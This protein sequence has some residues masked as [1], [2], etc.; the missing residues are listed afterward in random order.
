MKLFHL[1]EIRKQINEEDGLFINPS[2][3]SCNLFDWSSYRKV[4]IYL[5]LHPVEI[6]SQ[7]SK[8]LDQIIRGGFTKTS[9][10]KP[11][12]TG[13][14]LCSSNEYIMNNI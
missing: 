12:G 1:K 9:T 7:L 8:I 5:T 2:G 3:V 11:R 13:S 10:I 14:F 6:V 4:A